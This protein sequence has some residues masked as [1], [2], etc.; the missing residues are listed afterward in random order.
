MS[1]AGIEASDV[2]AEANDALKRLD[3]YLKDA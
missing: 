1:E 2:V 3:T